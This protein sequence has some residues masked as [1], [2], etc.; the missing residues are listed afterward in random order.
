MGNGIGEFFDRRERMRFHYLAAVEITV[1]SGE[2]LNG[3]LRD[4]AIESIYVSSNSPVLK[5][6]E[7]GE[8]V[9]VDIAVEENGSRL[10]ICSPGYVARRENNGVAIRFVSPL[11]WWPVFCFFPPDESFLP[12]VM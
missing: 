4:I 11:K 10:T 3:N 12:S 2:V 1:K 7:P 8:S 6:L 9:D 5:T